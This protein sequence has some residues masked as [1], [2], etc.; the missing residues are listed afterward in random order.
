MHR[1]GGRSKGH[2]ICRRINRIGTTANIKNIE[3]IV[4]C[5][6]CGHRRVHQG[7]R[8]I[9]RIGTVD[10]ECIAGRD[11]GAPALYPKDIDRRG[12][13]RRCAVYAEVGNFTGRDINQIARAPHVDGL[14]MPHRHVVQKDIVSFVAANDGCA[15]IDVV[16]RKR[17]IGS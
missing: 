10:I 12:V 16:I 17:G 2:R 6:T 11:S 8:A 5:T 1:I 7:Q 15:G 4:H 13:G 3:P 9:E 14:A